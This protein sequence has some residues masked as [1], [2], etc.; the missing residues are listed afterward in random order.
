MQMICIAG[1][2][3]KSICILCMWFFVRLFKK[4]PTVLVQVT[5][6]LLASVR[7]LLKRVLLAWV[8]VWGVRRMPCTTLANM[9]G[10][11]DYCWLNIMGANNMTTFTLFSAVFM[12]DASVILSDGAG[13][14]QTLVACDGQGCG[15]I[16]RVS[17]KI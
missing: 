10:A 1:K 7:A 12:A 15:K 16:T 17:P 13:G 6:S 14:G 2:A 3:A 11:G 9:R 8:R 5:V 4:T